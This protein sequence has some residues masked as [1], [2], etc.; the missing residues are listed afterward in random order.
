MTIP[1]AKG[2]LNEGDRVRTN[3]NAG[4]ASDEKFSGTITRLGSEDFWVR[5]DDGKLGGGGKD[6]DWIVNWDNKT[7]WIEVL[8]A[9]KITK[10]L[11]SNILDFFKN[12]T[13]SP[14]EKLRLKHG[15]EQP[16][17]TPTARGLELSALISYRANLAEIDKV[18]AQAEAEEGKA[19]K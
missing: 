15:L 19:E 3:G 14:A 1:Q 7:A 11:M 18:V 6:Q 9:E 10:P 5:R 2:V 8:T 13:A 16:L 4:R 17:G 12:V